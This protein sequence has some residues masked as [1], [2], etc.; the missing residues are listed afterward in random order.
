M[1]KILGYKQNTSNDNLK[2]DDVI[3]LLNRNGFDKFT[4]SPPEKEKDGLLFNEDN[5][6]P[7]LFGYSKDK[8][9]F[10][11]VVIGD[12]NKYHF[13]H[14]NGRRMHKNILEKRSCIC[15]NLKYHMKNFL[16]SIRSHKN[17]KNIF[18]IDLVIGFAISGDNFDKITTLTFN[19][20]QT[21]FE[22]I[23]RFIGDE[24]HNLD[25]IKD[26]S[27]SLMSL[28]DEHI[29]NIN[30]KGAIIK[31]NTKIISRMKFDDAIFQRAL[32]V[33]HADEI[34]ECYK[35][36][37]LERE[38]VPIT[39]SIIIGELEGNLYL[40]DG[41]HRISAFKKLSQEDK[42]NFDITIY[43]YS[44][45]NYTDMLFDFNIH[46]SHR[47]LTEAEE[48]HAKNPTSQV[49]GYLV[50]SEEVMLYLTKLYPD[51]I[52][53]KR[54]Y[55]GAMN[56]GEVKNRIQTALKN[57][58]IVVN[59]SLEVIEILKRKDKEIQINAKKAIYK[60]KPKHVNALEKSCEKL[61]CWLGFVNNMDWFD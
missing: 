18:D 28:C 13:E 4:F 56:H 12:S 59:S 42:I 39:S 55:R 49:K 5:I 32:D 40:I 50:L 35:K 17:K 29:S 43:F 60:S 27:I 22:Y 15:Y 33:L 19:L 53:H 6:L 57:K 9:T 24:I 7:D 34:R 14:E 1:V 16:K 52:R 25:V 44:Y 46:N 41:Q 51:A 3:P 61:G 26:R 47:S 2:C 48:Q 11:I 38:I 36:N 8:K 58:E 21:G 20:K 30:N 23:P 10:L 54:N 37:I 31:T 45:E